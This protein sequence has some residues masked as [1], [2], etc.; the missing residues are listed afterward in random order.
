MSGVFD[1]MT[2]SSEDVLDDFPKNESNGSYVAHVRRISD[3]SGHLRLY[4]IC[5]YDLSFPCGSCGGRERLNFI[6]D[7]GGKRIT[8]RGLQANF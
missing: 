7:I 3:M 1:R 8:Q 4:S 5:K 6:E 2:C